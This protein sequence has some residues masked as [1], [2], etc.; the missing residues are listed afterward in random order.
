MVSKKARVVSNGKVNTIKLR[1]TLI[2]NN[3][4]DGYKYKTQI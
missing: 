1:N 3:E 4:M 2:I